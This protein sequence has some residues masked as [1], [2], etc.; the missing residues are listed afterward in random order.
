MKAWT[1]LPPKTRGYSPVFLMV[2]SL[3]PVRGILQLLSILALLVLGLIAMPLLMAGATRTFTQAPSGIGHIGT[4]SSPFT[5][6][7]RT[8]Q[9]SW[10]LTIWQLARFSRLETRPV[11]RLVVP[12]I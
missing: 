6:P 1:R 9:P 12:I 8:T 7:R 5:C 3:T 11:F 2:R 10:E 4:G